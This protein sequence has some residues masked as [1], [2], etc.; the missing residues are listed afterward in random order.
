MAVSSLKN[1]KKKSPWLLY[2]VLG[3]LLIVAGTIFYFSGPEASQGF[4]DPTF[5]WKRLIKPLLR[6]T[7]L[8]SLGLFAGQVIE[9]SGWTGR[10]SMI[11]RPLMRWGH[12][13]DASGASFTTAF[14]S[15]TAAQAML[16]SF[17]EEGKLTRKE[18]ILTS[19]LNGLPAY[20]LHLPTTFFIILPLAG[21]A[22]LLYLVLTLI[23]TLLRTAGLVTYARMSLPPRTLEM[24]R[25]ERGRKPWKDLFLDTWE[26]FLKRLRRI[27]LLVIP[28]YLVVMLVSQLGFFTWLRLKLAGGI[29]ATVV[30]IEAMSVVIFS[31]VAE[32]TSGFAAAG[33]LLDAGTLTIRE[34]VIALLLGNVVATPVRAIR[35][36][37]P[38][39]MGI[40]RPK[41]GVL[42]ITLG[43]TLRVI[44]I[45]I[46]G[47]VYVLLTA[48]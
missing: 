14:V 19:L 37:L 39:Y 23:A 13:S 31:L 4:K 34:T 12:L 15:G 32:F 3:L 44:S 35:H 2:A 10:L 36:Q 18:V 21:Q 25:Q 26:K 17:H 40:F 7:L 16:V 5:L 9:G 11:V 1:D 27:M 28:V 33:A 38:H 41:L 43:Q 30:P 46:V 8:I 20:F 42:L 6:L 45:I 24:A 47:T 48:F 22:G 29:T